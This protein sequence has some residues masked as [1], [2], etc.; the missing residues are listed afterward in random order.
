MTITLNNAD[1]KVFEALQGLKAIKS[2]LEIIKEPLNYA[3]AKADLERVLLECDE[4][5][6]YSF[7]EMKARTSK[8]LDDENHLYTR[9]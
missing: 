2:D 5:V 4:G 8:H 1:N 7:D 6:F 3:Q 9:L